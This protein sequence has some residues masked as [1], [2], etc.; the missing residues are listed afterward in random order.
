MRIIVVFLFLFVVKSAVA[1]TVKVNWQTKAPFS[2]YHT[3]AWRA[4]KDQGSHFYRQWVVKDVNAELA[5][6]G[7]RKVTAND[8]P[9]L[10][11]Y[12]HVLT[13]EVINAPVTDDDG[14][15]WGDGDWGEWGGWGGDEGDDEDG[16]MGDYQIMARP[17]MMGVLSVDLA[18]PNR[19]EMV[20]RG[21]ATTDSISNNQRGDERQVLK[22]IR[23]MFQQ[24][25]P[26]KK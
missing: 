10:Y 16:G 18:D 15:G 19:K 14:Y 2:K 22:S 25:P 11:V 8:K 3:Y 21:Q 20:W 9:D 7:L 24:Y 12:Y 4:S 23:K 26:K 6:K 1:Q 17:Q 5:A 13:Q